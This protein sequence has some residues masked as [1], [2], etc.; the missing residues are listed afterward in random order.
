[1]DRTTFYSAAFSL[2]TL[3]S[4]QSA[5]CVASETTPNASPAATDKC[6]PESIEH[7]DT[8]VF[9][10]D[11]R[12]KYKANRNTRVAGYSSAK[13]RVELTAYYYDRDTWVTGSDQKELIDSIREVL[14][15]H[16]GAELSLQGEAELPLTGIETKADVAIFFWNEQG[17]SFGSFLWLIPAKTHYLKLRVTYVLPPGPQEDAIEFVKETTDR[18]VE[19]TC[20]P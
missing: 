20:R 12:N 14:A 2:F 1:M 11:L 10:D 9:T 15:A 17:V 19:A 13:Y 3:S 18:V 4:I 8:I 6:F 16:P 7:F 5:Y